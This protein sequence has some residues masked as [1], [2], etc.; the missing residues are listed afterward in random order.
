MIRRFNIFCI[1]SMFTLLACLTNVSAQDADQAAGARAAAMEAHAA[2]LAPR[3]LKTADKTRTKAEK[4]TA[5]GKDMGKAIEQYTQATL[6]YNAAK[7]RAM[8]SANILSSTITARNAAIEADA[9]SYA[10][11]SW[12][13]AYEY[14]EDAVAALEK[15]RA[16]KAQSASMNAQKN[17]ELTELE[18]IQNRIL[19]DARAAIEAA[20]DASADDYAP[21]TFERAQGLAA[22]AENALV[23]D[24][25]GFEYAEDLALQA[26]QA[27]HHSVQIRDIVRSDPDIEELILLWTSYIGRAQAA[28]ELAPPVDQDSELAA[29][30]LAET[31]E[32]LVASERQLR[33]DLADF[34]SFSAA[35]ED[36]IRELDQ[37]LGGASAERRQLVTRLEVQARER[38]KINQTE[39]IF[40]PSQAE[41]FKQSNTI[42]VRLIGLKFG[43]GSA[44]FNEGNDEILNKLEQVIAL[45]P[46]STLVIEGHT[47]ARGSER[48]NLRLS[49]NR[50]DAVMNHIVASMRLP[51]TRISALGYGESRPI[52]SNKNGAGRAKNRR[53]DLLISP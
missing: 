6:E 49:Q 37:Q 15:G 36:E 9:Q 16:D 11:D 39:G 17:F 10:A 52:A 48:L 3:A 29:D 19:A 43:S 20:E 23:E 32:T 50:A 2:V 27:A 35:L 4:T 24:R 28:A 12:E 33:R 46:N 25:Y 51:A 21:I 44:D 38:E 34:E 30:E 45:W 42:I 47:D 13:D 22:A 14:F 7:D 53:I 26:Q 1:V 8:A 5:R 41:V 40:R 31:I 18:A